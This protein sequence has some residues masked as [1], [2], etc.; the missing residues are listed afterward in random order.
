[1]NSAIVYNSVRIDEPSRLRVIISGLKKV[2]G[3][4]RVVEVPSIAERVQDAD[5]GG[6]GTDRGQQFAPAVVDIFHYD[7]AGAVIKSNHVALCIVQVIVV[8]AIEVDAQCDA[9]RIVS[10]IQDVGPVGHRDQKAGCIGVLGTG[11]VLRF[12]GP[13]SVCVLNELVAVCIIIRRGQLSSVLPGE[14]HAVIA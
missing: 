6:A 1:M 10:E 13:L 14:G 3:K 12:P 9:V 8:G 7:G 11:I 2:Q 4:V 5:G